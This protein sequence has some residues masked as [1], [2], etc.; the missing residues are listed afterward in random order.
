[1][2][3]TFAATAAGILCLAAAAPAFAAFQLEITEVWSGNFAAPDATPDWFEVTNRGSTAF[4]FGTGVGQDGNLYFDDESDDPLSSVQL[5]GVTSINPGETVVFVDNGAAGVSQF[6]AFWGALLPASLTKIGRYTN[7]SSG[8][9]NAGDAVNLWVS[10]TPPT[11]LTPLTA[12]VAFPS[13]VGF[14][15]ASYDARLHAFSVVGNAASAVS[16]DSPVPPNADPTTA[17]PGRVQS[18]NS[19]ALS[20]DLR[21]TEIWP[22]NVVSPDSTEDWFELTNLGNAAYVAQNHGNLYFDDS[23]ASAAAAVR[24][25]GITTIPAHTSVIFTEIADTGAQELKDFWEPRLGQT[26]SVGTFQ[27]SGLSLSGTSGD[28]INIWLLPAPPTGSD[29]IS[30]SASF[31][32]GSNGASRDIQLNAFSTPGNAANAIQVIRAGLPPEPTTASPGR[33]APATAAVPFPG[34]W[35]APALAGLG[36]WRL[37]RRRR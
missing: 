36:A 1:M 30:F 19:G 9:S 17:S 20:F 34:W 25:L 24:L 31:P 37:R 22:G 4:V 26:L 6:T 12:R 14:R 27:G 32:A 21:V 23:S 2:R 18:N 11:A 33:L 5:Q 7:D 28:A 3:K 8:L 13:T 10:G 15:G 29:P 16:R 35:L